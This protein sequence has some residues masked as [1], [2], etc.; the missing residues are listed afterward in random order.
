MTNLWEDGCGRSWRWKDL[1]IETMLVCF[2]SGV[3][4]TINLAMI[5][6]IGKGF[7]KLLMRDFICWVKSS[8]VKKCFWILSRRRLVFMTVLVLCKLML[9][10]LLLKIGFLA[11]MKLVLD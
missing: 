10:Q 7:V 11:V 4:T 9:W 3:R 2:I 1:D 6:F 5:A 8:T